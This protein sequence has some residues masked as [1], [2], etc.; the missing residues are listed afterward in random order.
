MT[1]HCLVTGVLWKDPEARQSKAGKAFTAATLR[2]KDG[3]QVDWLKILAFSD[4][5]QAELNRLGDGDRC[6]V[7][8][9]LKCDFYTPEGGVPR[10][11]MTIFA[12]S[13]LALR[14][15]PKERKPKQDQRRPEHAAT[16]QPAWNDDVPFGPCL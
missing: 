5:T 3:D 8:G 4:H 6:S 14:Q 15:P 10:I 13:I 12:D 9:T 11:S 16:A 2:I 1:L 7:Q